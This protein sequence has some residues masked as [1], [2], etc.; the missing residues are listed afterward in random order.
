MPNKRRYSE[1][2]ERINLLFS[3]PE[4]ESWKLGQ[5]LCHQYNINYNVVI[6]RILFP[7]SASSTGIARWAPYTPVL[8]TTRNVNTSG[9]HVHVKDTRWRTVRSIWI[10]EGIQCALNVYKIKLNAN[11]KNK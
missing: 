6:K 3:A 1:I 9:R 4:K 7:A 10:N 8:Y 11:T 2:I 5:I